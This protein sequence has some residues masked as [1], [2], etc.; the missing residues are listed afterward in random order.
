MKHLKVIS[1]S[2]KELP[3][4]DLGKLVLQENEIE[5]KLGKIKHQFDIPELFYVGTCNRVAFVFV[6]S[7]K[8]TQNF[9]DSLI[10]NLKFADMC[11]YSRQAVTSKAMIFEGEEALN[12]LFRTS[13]S[14]ESL[15]I[16]EKEILA[17]IRN[18]YEHCKTAG[19]TGDY[20]RLVMDRVVK[21]A[22]EVYT[23]TNI[24]KNPISVVSLA[25]RRLQ[26]LQKI[27]NARILIIGA[28]E[29]NQNFAQYL[30]KH[31]YSNFRVFN[32]TLSKA[33]QLAETLKGRA[34]SLD[35]LATYSEGF[36]ILITCTGATE[37]IITSEL[38]KNLLQGD[39][40]KKI[41]VDLAI[42][43]DTDPKVLKQFNVNFIGVQDLEQ[44]AERN[45]LKRLKEIENAESIIQQNIDE[46]YGVL[47][48]RK[49]ELAMSEIPKKVKEIRHNALDIV[50]EKEV[51]QLDSFSQETLNKILDYI[52]KKYISVPMLIA[53]DI[54]LEEA[55]H[56]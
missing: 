21:A 7:E 10:Q 52:E 37:Y 11:P 19:L 23:H 54:L 49:I 55:N 5:E 34:Y 26:K 56:E 1:F 9:V 39:T 12:H 14:L 36:D 53:K 22:K 41:I 20:L 48:Q 43:T 3:L 32:R 6:F 2:H 50:F 51:K 38:Y 31:Q 24:S 33:Q 29:T 18:A 35:D 16:G 4:S 27:S 15:V 47:K 44:E 28:G 46:F 17:Q 30:Q 8:P 40:D 45:K 42:P 25:Y 13:C